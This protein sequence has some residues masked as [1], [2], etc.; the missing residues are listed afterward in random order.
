MSNSPYLAKAL[1]IGDSLAAPRPHRGQTL[2]RT[3]PELIKSRFPEVDV[4]QRCRAASMSDDVLREFH[5][6]SDSLDFF[7]FL[8]VQVG[9]GDCC[10]RPYPYFLHRMIL[11]LAPPAF[12]RWINAHYPYLLKIRAK[13]WI[14]KLQYVKNLRDMATTAHERHPEMRITFIAIGEPSHSFLQKVPG[15]VQFQRDYNSAVRQMVEQLHLPGRVLYLDPYSSHDPKDIFIDDG[16]H[17]TVTGHRIIAEGLAEA[18]RGACD[19]RSENIS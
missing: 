1:L 17:L 16:H 19:F 9:I 5:L 13:P 18:W 12:I 7:H 4:W 11:A 3:W 15:I 8:V 10:P 14:S 6:F 2:D